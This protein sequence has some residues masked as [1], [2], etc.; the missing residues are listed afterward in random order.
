MDPARIELFQHLMQ[1]NNDIGKRGIPDSWAIRYH[2]ENELDSD[3]RPP[4]F[5][6]VDR[7]VH[8]KAY[9]RYIDCLLYTSPSP[10]DRQRSRM[11]SSA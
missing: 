11:P 3:I 6:D 7:I 8:S 10:R 2:E 9:A 1:K 5:R 4:F